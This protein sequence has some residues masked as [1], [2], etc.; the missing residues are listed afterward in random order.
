MIGGEAPS[1]TSPISIGMAGIT[2]A[3]HGIRAG[4]FAWPRGIVID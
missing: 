1:L 2:M 3:A 4:R